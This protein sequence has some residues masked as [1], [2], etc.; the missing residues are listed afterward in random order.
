MASI[1][2]TPCHSLWFLACWWDQWKIRC[3]LQ[4]HICEHCKQP[5]R[6][7]DRRER[8]ERER[9]TGERERQERERETEER[10]RQERGHS[11]TH[12]G[13]LARHKNRADKKRKKKEAK[14]A[15]GSKQ[16]NKSQDQ[17]LSSE[18]E[19]KEKKRESSCVSNTGARPPGSAARGAGSGRQLK[20]RGRYTPIR[21]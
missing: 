2:C 8:Q 3:S 5:Q 16:S 11:C 7:R 17:Y 18:R 21:T 20:P 6:E 19:E 4:R 12:T 15:K 9:E 1:W 14:I 13:E 10:E